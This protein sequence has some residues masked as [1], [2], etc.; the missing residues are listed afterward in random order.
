MPLGP[1]RERERERC[2]VLVLTKYKLNER[3]EEKT[4][5]EARKCEGGKK[6]AKGGWVGVARTEPQATR[7][8]K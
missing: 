2:R 5:R 7:T 6:R 1:E 3:I 4:T 8:D